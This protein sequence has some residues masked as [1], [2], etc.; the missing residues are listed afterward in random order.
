MS[1]EPKKPNGFL[2]FLK[3]FGISMGGYFILTEI[4][5]IPNIPLPALIL[6]ACVEL[7]AMGLLA[8]KF[9]RSG[10]PTIAITILTMIAPAIFFLLLA[11]A[12]SVLIPSM[13]N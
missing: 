9:F 3:G 7:A 6:A 4:S 10:R 5:I 8:V 1:D 13:F 2:E 11:G 12:C